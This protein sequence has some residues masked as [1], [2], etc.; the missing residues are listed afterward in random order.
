MELYSSGMSHYPLRITANNARVSYELYEVST[1]TVGILTRVALSSRDYLDLEV[2]G[3]RI[4]FRVTAVFAPMRPAW[5]PALRRYR[6]TCLDSSMDLDQW[7]ATDP[8]SSQR[9]QFPR[10]MVQPRLYVEMK[11]PAREDLELLESVDISRSGMLLRVGPGR[12]CQPAEQSPFPLRV[13]VARLWL[14]ESLQPVGRIVRCFHAQEDVREYSYIA[15]ELLA[16]N[17]QDAEHWKGF[18][19]RIERGFLPGTGKLG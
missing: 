8:G 9:L 3:R 17:P 16:F 6:L 11:W 19:R 14:P 2:L 10:C 18:L 7:L 5:G 13:D 1:C 15:I 4:P 12:L